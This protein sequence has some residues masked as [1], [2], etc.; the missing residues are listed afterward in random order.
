MEKR[1]KESFRDLATV[2][3]PVVDVV[4]INRWPPAGPPASFLWTVILLQ[5][6][7]LIYT[8]FTIVK[9]II[10][11]GS[12]IGSTVVSFHCYLISKQS[13]LCWSFL[14][15]VNPSQLIV[16]CFKP[17][18]AIFIKYKETAWLCA[19]QS[20]LLVL[21]FIMFI[22][23]SLA[24]WLWKKFFFTGAGAGEKALAPGCCCVA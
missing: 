4:H 24:H 17:L 11:G 13:N 9:A 22:I 3:Q 7:F 23:L 16:N 8:L 14:T 2:T 20:V 10:S 15:S 6:K 18:I 19:A 21:P 5:V 12:C 1:A